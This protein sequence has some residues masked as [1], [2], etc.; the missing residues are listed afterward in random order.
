MIKQLKAGL[1]VLLLSP[2]AAFA[3]D[4]EHDVLTSEIFA[5]HQDQV[6]VKGDMMADINR[7]L[8]MQPTAAGAEQKSLYG[9][10]GISL[11]DTY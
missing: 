4:A 6:E 10:P 2:V 9:Y 3:T 8:D 1:V 11:E 7:T 5:L